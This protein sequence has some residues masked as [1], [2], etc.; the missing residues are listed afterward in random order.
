MSARVTVGALAISAELHDFVQRALAGTG[1]EPPAFWRSLERIL[2]QFSPRN[3]QL[4]AKR[5]ALQARC[6]WT[7]DEVIGP[8]PR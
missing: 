1:I 7:R 5:D 2:G 3:E 8:P 4:L 6:E